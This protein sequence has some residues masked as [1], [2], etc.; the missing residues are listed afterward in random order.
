[1]ESSTV[2]YPDNN[3]IILSYTIV[4]VIIIVHK[5][6]TNFFFLCFYLLYITILC[7]EDRI[8]KPF[9]TFEAV[10]MTYFVCLQVDVIHFVTVRHV[11]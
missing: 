4:I 3:R 1:M 6:C 7:I 2:L 5:Q 11:Y 9:Q 8:K 10:F